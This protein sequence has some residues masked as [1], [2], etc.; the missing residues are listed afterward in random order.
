[1]LMQKALSIGLFL[2][3]LIYSGFSQTTYITREG[4]ISFY[5]SAPLEDI[6]AENNR[7]QAVLSTSTGEISVRLRIEDFQFS[8]SLMQR[9]F[10]ERFME[11]DIYPEARLIGII[12]DFEKFAET[13]GEVNVTGELTIHGVTRDVEITGILRRS[14]PHYIC[15]ATFPVRVDDYDIEIPRLLIRNIAEVVDVTVDLRLAPLD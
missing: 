4:T 13:G 3:M 10:N 2:T 11:S 1:M 9:H 15:H 8:R 14:G 6:E 7:V 5:S 12:D